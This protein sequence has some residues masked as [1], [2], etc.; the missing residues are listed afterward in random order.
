MSQTT[1]KVLAFSLGAIFG[2]AVWS[3]FCHSWIQAPG[4]NN[5][6][7]VAD[8]TLER[9]ETGV[10]D[11][12]VRSSAILQQ[13]RA[14]QISLDNLDLAGVQ[15]TPVPVTYGIGEATGKESKTVGT[16]DSSQQWLEHMPKMIAPL[17]VARGLSPYDDPRIAVLVRDAILGLTAADREYGASMDRWRQLYSDEQMSRSEWQDTQQ[18]LLEQLHA[19][20]QSVLDPLVGALDEI[21][22]ER[23]RTAAKDQPG[24]PRGE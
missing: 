5:V 24:G 1:T 10:R 14:L 21:L 9:V 6:S 11:L 15:R 19:Q 4:A 18:K 23:L 3:L 2:V 13:L 7:P 12:A 16:S 20:Q 22:A 8:G 17:L